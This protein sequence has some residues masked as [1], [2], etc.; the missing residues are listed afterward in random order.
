MFRVFVFNPHVSPFNVSSS[1]SCEVPSLIYR[2][3]QFYSSSFM[4]LSIGAGAIMLC[5]GSGNIRA[6]TW[7]LRTQNVPT[8]R[9]E[10]LWHLPLKRV[11]GMHNGSQRAEIAS[12]MSLS[13][14]LNKSKVYWTSQRADRDTV[15]RKN[16]FNVGDVGLGPKRDNRISW[17]FR[18]FWWQNC[19]VRL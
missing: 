6:T 15:F 8:A 9:R 10:T 18:R 16:T 5:R 11:G 17:F 12:S 2:I 3:S 1:M 7:R 4:F 13:C 19:S 14:V